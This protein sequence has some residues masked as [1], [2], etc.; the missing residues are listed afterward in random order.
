MP[1]VFEEYSLTE[2][3]KKLN[4]ADAWIRRWEKALDFKGSSGQQGKRSYY[5]KEFIDVLNRIHI[6]QALNFNNKQILR[7]WKMELALKKL[8]GNKGFPYPLI[9]IDPEKPL[10]LDYG[11]FNDDLKFELL[12][13]HYHFSIE[14]HH[15]LEALQFV[16]KEFIDEGKKGMDEKNREENTQALLKLGLLVREMIAREK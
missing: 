8:S 1:S 5:T 3:A 13:S 4:V 7:L 11:E 12:Q 9:I 10:C 14:V 16:I 15:A 6:L 2:V